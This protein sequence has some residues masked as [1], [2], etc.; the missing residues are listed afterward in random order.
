MPDRVA[1]ARCDRH[2][3]AMAG[4]VA[5]WL[6]Q[7]ELHATRLWCSIFGGLSSYGTGGVRG[8]HQ[9]G[10]LPAGGSGVG[11]AAARFKVQPL[12]MVG[13][14]SKGWLKTRLGKT[15]ATQDVEHRC[16]VDGARQPS[17]TA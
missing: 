13:G 15:G 12:A 14:C 8:I 6:A 9:G 10:L 11:H 7:P 4:T 5:P 2:G 17:Y 3:R 16:R 1:A